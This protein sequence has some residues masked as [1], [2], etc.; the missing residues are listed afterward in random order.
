MGLSGVD[1]LV[2]RLGG[3]SG[4]VGCVLDADVMIEV[5][6]MV[7]VGRSGLLCQCR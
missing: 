5:V 3:G 2:T 6:L 1:R 7:F 4:Y